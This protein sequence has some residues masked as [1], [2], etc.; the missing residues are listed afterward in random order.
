M[1]RD[2]PALGADVQDLGAQAGDAGV[3]GRFD[4]DPELVAAEPGQHP[5][6]RHRSRRR[7]ADLAHQL[8]AGAVAKGVVDRLEAVE[9]DHQHV[10]VLA[11]AGEARGQLLD[12]AGAVEDAR[13]I[14]VARGVFGDVEPRAQFLDLQLQPLDRRAGVVGGAF[15][16][17]QP[18]VALGDGADGRLGRARIERG[19]QEGQLVRRSHHLQAGRERRTVAA[20]GHHQ[21]FGGGVGLPNQSHLGG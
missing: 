17:G 11:A 3:G 9:V 21:Q 7:R 20:L 8:V 2:Q 1:A 10:L 12:E 15:G 18:A 14:V 13:Q 19:Q 6:G 5:A 4:D 16:V